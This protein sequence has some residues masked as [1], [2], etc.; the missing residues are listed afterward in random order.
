VH[1]KCVS[2]S[3]TESHT[4]LILHTD[5]ACTGAAPQPSGQRE[6]H[7]GAVRPGPAAPGNTTQLCAAGSVTSYGCCAISGLQLASSEPAQTHTTKTTT[8]TSTSSKQVVWRMF[9]W[10]CVACKLRCIITYKKHVCGCSCRPGWRKGVM[11]LSLGSATTGGAKLT[12]THDLSLVHAHPPP[13]Q[14]GFN[15]G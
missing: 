3:H 2:R 8:T 5:T 15:D 9:P 6:V 14:H 12:H 13:L 10:Q 7:G 1:D 4:F 11:A